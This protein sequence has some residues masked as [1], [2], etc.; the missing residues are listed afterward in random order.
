MIGFSYPTLLVLLLGSA[1]AAPQG[2]I[3]PQP[4]E[5]SPPLPESSVPPQ[6]IPPPENT[7]PMPSIPPRIS[8]PAQPSAPPEEA[9]PIRSDPV[10]VSHGPYSGVPTTTG[11]LSNDVLAPTI[12]ALPPNPTATTYPSDGQL[13]DPQPAPY[14]PA[15]GLG[16]NGTE[17]IYNVKSDFDYQSLVKLS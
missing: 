17:P 15:G 2:G 13:H 11:A 16:T 3:P 6:S 10:G 8:V 5:P 9:P 12:A 4:P 14:V 7:Q 1:Y